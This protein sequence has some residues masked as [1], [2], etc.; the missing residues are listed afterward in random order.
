MLSSICTQNVDA[1]RGAYARRT[2]VKRELWME[3]LELQTEK[4]KKEK[5]LLPPSREGPMLEGKH[6]SKREKV[7][8]KKKD[9]WTQPQGGEYE[10]K[11]WEST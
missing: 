9:Q 8:I 11:A 6:A 7:K 1:R 3:G 2:K 10:G 5:R 4:G